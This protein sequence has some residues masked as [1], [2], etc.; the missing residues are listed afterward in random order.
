[1]SLEKIMSVAGKPGLFKVVAQSKSGFVVEAL[2]DNKRTVVDASQRVSMLEDISI[3]T[4]AEEKPLNE[5]LQAIRDKDGDQVPVNAKSSPADLKNYFKTILPDYD[6]ERVY[7]S[8]IKKMISWYSLLK[9]FTFEA[10]E[11]ES[12]SEGEGDDQAAGKP[13][14]AGQE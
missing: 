11:T 8:D 1:M 13:E 5:V 10:A 4:L 3:Y 6:E 7:L 14:E 9:D 12:E 2:T